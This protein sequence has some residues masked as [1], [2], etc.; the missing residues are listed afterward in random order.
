MRR[1]VDIISLF[2]KYVHWRSQ[3][4]HIIKHVNR[5]YTIETFW[6]LWRGILTGRSNCQKLYLQLFKFFREPYNEEERKTIVGNRIFNIEHRFKQIA[7][8][9]HAIFNCSI[10]NIE[11]IKD[12]RNGLHS[13]FL[14]C[15]MCNIVQHLTNVK[16]D[17][18]A[19]SVVCVLWHMVFIYGKWLHPDKRFFF[20]L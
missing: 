5:L 4:M 12:I 19:E 20:Q 8:M 13:K 16:K 1:V 11:I 14:L 10:S 9:T 6:L 3:R 2:V 17:L 7:G 18:T 15:K